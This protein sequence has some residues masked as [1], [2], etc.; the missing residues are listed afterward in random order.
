MSPASGGGLPTVSLVI[1]SRG[2]AKLLGRLL[3]AIRF[4]D[5]PAF[6]VVVVSD[7]DPDHER[8]RYV[9][10]DRANISAAR[11]YGL[12]H[13]A[14]DVVAFC[15]D[16]AVPEPSWLTHLV[17]PFEDPSV[18]AAGGYVIGRNGISF[19]W[20][21]R[22]FDRFGNHTTL[23]LHGNA[24]VVLA[25]N[26]GRG[27]KTEGTN[28]AFRAR[29]LR[30]IGGFDENFCYY[31]D[32]TDVNAR[33]GLAGWKTAIV[34]LARVHHG[35]AASA[36][37][38]ANRAPKSLF[39]IGA[40]K[41]WFCRKHATNHEMEDELSDF[42]AAQRRRLIGFML[43]GDLEPGQVLKMMDGLDAGIADGLKRRE[44]EPVLGQE[45]V[46]FTPF[47]PRGK[48]VQSVGIVC[49]PLEWRRVRPQVC[50]LAKKGICVTVFCLSRTGL[51]HRMEFFADGYWLQT[52]GIFGR[53]ERRDPLFRHFSLTGRG[54]AEQRRLADVRP[55]EIYPLDRLVNSQ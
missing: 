4:L 17:A 45:Q 18:G 38:R 21:G 9:A 16:D 52:G 47:Q 12:A 55:L 29:A 33:L 30:E 46:T 31:L 24:P 32:E 51:F 36:F 44:V 2:R 35:F 26:A 53:A 42:R 43:R 10:F 49:R 19:Q 5:Y 15:D 48:H 3:S 13:A 23:E 14:G 1:V 34:P 20:T 39:E 25:G 41:A 50:A 11:N 22:S 6:E 54:R 8:I 37:R 40:S 28:S 27:I 7:T